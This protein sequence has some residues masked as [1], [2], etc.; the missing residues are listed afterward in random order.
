MASSQQ[1]LE[2][3][4]ARLALEEEDEWGI[5][6]GEDEVVNDKQ[7]FILVGRFLTEKN[8]NFLAMQNIVASLWRLREGVEIY[9]LGNCRYSF[10]F[11]HVLDI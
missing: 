6:I 3:M 7:M 8:I 2:E 9:D 4:Y 10:I 5:L 11:Y 1:N